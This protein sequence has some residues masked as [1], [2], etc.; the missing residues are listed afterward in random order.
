MKTLIAYAT[1]YGATA[2]TSEEIAKILREEGFDVKVVNLKEEKVKAITEYD[3]IIV[4][5]GLQM[6]RWVGEAEN[7]L[8]KFRKELATKK[9]ALF[10]SSM[11]E[12]LKREGKTEE[13]EQSWKRFLEDK[14]TKY[15]LHP[16]S[17]GM[18][19]G[20]LDFNK[21]NFLIRRTM[22]AMKEQLEKD[23]FKENPAG[24][25]DMRDWDEIRNWARDLA[26]KAR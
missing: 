9:V 4:G 11:K 15:G 3:L 26:N 24:V 19:G 25:Y 13:L 6:F 1:R 20:V 22:G 5:S 8:N 18:F 12:A 16:L 23:G 2:G 17:M 14:T 21:M 7:F 10:V